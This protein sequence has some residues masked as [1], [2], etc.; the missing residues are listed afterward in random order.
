MGEGKE[1]KEG[2]GEKARGGVSHT[3]G[4]SSAGSVGCGAYVVH[5]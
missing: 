4:V 5:V 1:G 3:E 2:A